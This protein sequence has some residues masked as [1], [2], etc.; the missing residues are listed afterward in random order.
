[1]YLLHHPTTMALWYEIIHEAGTTCDIS[2]RDE[3]ES[4]LVHLMM[5]YTS[6]P[7]IVRQMIAMDFMTGMNQRYRQ[8]QRTLQEVGDHCLIISGLFPGLAKKRLVTLDYYVNIGRTSYSTISVSDHDLY[9]GLS[10]D[11]VLLMDILQSLRCVD[12]PDLLP[13]DAYELWL[14]TGSKRALSLCKQYSQAV[15]WFFSKPK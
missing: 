9:A 15:P 13:L 8:K 11:F 2:L 7:N 4:Y 3:L 1:M 10:K 6:D 12:Y 14:E 5:R